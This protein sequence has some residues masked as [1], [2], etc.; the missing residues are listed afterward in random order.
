MRRSRLRF[1]GLFLLLTG[2]LYSL[3]PAFA[4]ETGRGGGFAS[5]AVSE[6][7]AANVSY[8][9]AGQ[10]VSAVEFDLNAPARSAVA[11]PGSEWARCTLAGTHARCAF[12]TP[13][14]VASAT[15]LSFEAVS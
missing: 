4:A 11:S 14:S 5:A 10:G 12:T 1:L 13:P 9:L 8:D 6:Y 15:S 2:F 3:T 7:R